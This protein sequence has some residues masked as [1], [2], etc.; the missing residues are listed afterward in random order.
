M[1]MDACQGETFSQE[2]KKQE[3]ATDIV[4]LTKWQKPREKQKNSFD[5]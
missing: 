1:P 3:K 4:G 2:P 5:P